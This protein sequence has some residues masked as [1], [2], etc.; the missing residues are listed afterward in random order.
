MN[1]PENPRL[2]LFV[3]D[4]AQFLGTIERLMRLWSHDAWT[5]LTAPSASTAMALLQQHKPNLIVLDVCMPIVDGLQFLSIVHRRYPDIQK[6]ALTGFATEAYRTACLA[7]GAELFLE[8]PKSPEAFDSIFHTFDELTKWKPEE[9]F[10]GV[11]RRVGL[12]EIIQMECLNKSSSLLKV[13]SPGLSGEIYICDGAIVHAQAGRITG[14][15]AVNSLFTLTGGDFSLNSYSEPPE[16]TI[17]AQWEFLLMDA[18]QKR[19]ESGPAPPPPEEKLPAARENKGSVV[20]SAAEESARVEEL[21]IC[22]EMGDV[23]HSW[24]CAESDL[25][26]NF[27]EF[28]SQKGRL[29]RNAL[30]MGAF[31]R[32]E[33]SSGPERFIAK[34]AA[35]QG[36]ILRTTKGDVEAR[37]PKSSRVGPPAAPPSPEIRASATVHF[38]QASKLP[39]VLAVGLHFS[40]GHGATHTLSPTFTPEAVDVLRRSA[41]DGFR[42]LALQGFNARQAS[43]KYEHTIVECA[44]WRQ[45][46][47]LA[48][49]VGRQNVEVDARPIEDAIEAFLAAE[50]QTP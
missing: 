43:W 46:V 49:A 16:R 30:P 31:D 28:I 19:D 48:L 32:V 9:G 3:D 23:L 36:I 13:S 45:G 12:T 47:C 37:G 11:L 6:V 35:G 20:P 14:E 21:M 15:E 1:T 17:D 2:V 42:V 5:V 33:F 40:D 27:L 10:R 29:L 8:K 18:A 39:G 22:T 50:P 24:Q 41:N 7:N 34:V 25:R 26:I 38:D 4:D 44:A